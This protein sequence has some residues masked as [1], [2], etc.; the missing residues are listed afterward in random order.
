VYNFDVA[1]PQPIVPEH[2]RLELRERL[3]FTGATLVAL[4]QGDLERLSVWLAEQPLE[5]LAICL[6]HSYAN[7]AHEQVVAA[8]CA[9]AAPQLYIS[10]SHQVLPEPREYERTSTTVVNAYVGPVLDRYLAQLDTALTAQGVATLRLMASDGG[11]MGLRTARELAARATLSG[12]AGGIVGARFVARRAGFERVITFDMGGTSTDVALCDGGLPRSGTSNVGGLP[13][14]LPSLDIHTVGAGGG[15][16][17]RMDAG[18]ALRVGPE[19]AGADPGPACYGRGTQPTVTDANLLLGRLLPDA[20][21]G[22]RMALD[23]GRARA[24]LQ[25]ITQ[26]LAGDTRQAHAAGADERAALGVLRVANAAME[27]AIR[28]ISVE[29]GDDPR[30]FAL[31]A[32]GGAGPLHAAH[33]ADVLGM[34]TVIVP[35]YPGV[36][37]ALGMLAADVTRDASRSLLTE[38]Q[39]LDVARLN[40]VLRELAGEVVAALVAD[41]EARERCRVEFSLE[42]RYRGQSHEIDTAL[43]DWPSLDDAAAL[44]AAHLA[45]AAERFHQLHERRS[46]HTM[47]ERPIEAVLLRARALSERPELTLEAELAVRPATL[48]PRA[49]IRA[50]LT[51]H[52][53]ELQPAQLYDRADLRPGD[54]L[55]GPAVVAQLDATTIIPPGWA[56]R[57]D[58][59]LNMILMAEG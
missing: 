56:A 41:G 3:D 27:R 32:F 47:R 24:A 52:S 20:F 14:H 45:A 51:N 50:A 1:R 38:L 12:P 16:L 26:A 42:L 4:D 44:T 23:I 59:D 33:L 9:A 28:T 10:T 57:V 2:W 15:S 49:T 40:G 19:S 53:H 6:L 31:V 30:D 25:P 43:C 35:R 37:S 34:R 39:T 21:L 5:A 17:A 58:D 8:V 29:R 11:S 48:T 46:G 18:G 54:E 22:G 55:H 36:L 7:P 13:V